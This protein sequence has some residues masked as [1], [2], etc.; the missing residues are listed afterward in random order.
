MGHSDPSEA[1]TKLQTTVKPS[2]CPQ[3]L[4]CSVSASSLHHF[5]LPTLP[6]I[7]LTKTFFPFLFI[8]FTQH[9]HKG[10]LHMLTQN[11]NKSPQDKNICKYMVQFQVSC[12]SK[13][14]WKFTKLSVN[15]FQPCMSTTDIPFLVLPPLVIDIHHW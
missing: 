1:I 6:T 13:N 4:C 2:H 10:Q 8:L 7:S 9:K 12:L 14:V 15:I 11:N 3:L 5:I